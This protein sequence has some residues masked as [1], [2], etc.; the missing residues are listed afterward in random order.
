MNVILIGYPGSGKGTQANLLAEEYGFNHI[1]TGDLIR[2]EIADKT[3]LGLKLEDGI[4][5][6]NLASDEDT[7]TLLKN[8]AKNLKGSLIFDGFPRTIPQAQALD[9]QLKGTDFK[10]IVLNLPEEE[11][12]KRLTSRRVCEVCGRAYNIYSPDFKDKCLADGGVLTTRPD[13]SLQSAKHRLEVF[14]KETAPLLAWYKQNTGY[15]E[16][17]GNQS[18]QAVYADILKALGLKK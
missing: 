11:V 14:E 9:A 18:V 1:S 6:G 8:A 12:L 2:K 4:S 5:K 13:D 16:V 7:M 10:I 17:N 3:P 15:H